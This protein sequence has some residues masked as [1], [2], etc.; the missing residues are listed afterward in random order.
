[1]A[2]RSSDVRRANH[3]R[4]RPSHLPEVDVEHDNG[5]AGFL[6]A[7]NCFAWFLNDHHGDAP[8]GQLSRVA[9]KRLQKFVC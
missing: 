6:V 4:K 2:V 7:D 5:Q 9:P 1:M 3:E 8:E